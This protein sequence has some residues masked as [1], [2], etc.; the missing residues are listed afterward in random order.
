MQALPQV[1]FSALW[2]LD[3]CRE[4]QGQSWLLGLSAVSSRAGAG[5]LGR[6]GQPG[7]AV[8]WAWWSPGAYTGRREGQARLP[9]PGVHGALR[10]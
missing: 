6:P 7:A 10:A 8:A 3:Q 9:I 1:A 2:E 4:L 5:T